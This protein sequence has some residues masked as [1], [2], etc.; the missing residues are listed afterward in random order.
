MRTGFAGQSHEYYVEYIETL[1][2]LDQPARA[3]EV[4]ERSRA[5][6]LLM[7]LAER[8]LVLDTDLSPEVV[9]ARKAL[10]EEYDQVQ[11]SLTELNPGQQA[12]EVDRLQTRLR[13]LRESRA[14]IVDKIRGESRRL[15][16]L[17]YPKP[18]T[19]AGMQQALDPGTALLSYHIGKE[20]SRLFVVEP[21]AAGQDGQA[22]LTVHAIPV[23]ETA[24]REQVAA[25][26]RQ[27]EHQAGSRDVASPWFLELSRRLFDV[28]IAPAESALAK[29]D[30]VLISPDGPL[31]SLPFAALVRSTGELPVS[32][33]R[34][35]E[36]LVEWKPLHTAVSATVYEE[37][38]KLRAVSTD[39]A[40]LVA[41]GD[42]QYPSSKTPADSQNTELRAMLLRGYTL[43]S[44]PATRT[45]VEALGRVFGDRATT[46]L[47]ASATEERAKSVGRTR[48]LHFATHGLLDARFPLNSALALSV[49]LQR[50][51]GQDNGLLQAWEIFEQVR[52]DADLVTLSACETALGAE[53]AGEGLISLTRAFHYA[54]ARSVLASLWSVADDST[55]D[56]MRAVYRHL[57]AGVPKDEALRRA[58]RDAITQRQTSL[59]FH[60]AAFTLS[61]D[62]R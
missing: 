42:P 9:E 43:D 2:A 8:D 7:V 55:A 26:R 14:R 17:Q 3:F 25:L 61:G 49:P 27:I 50:R 1:L 58:Q 37:L 56:L 21:A 23:G 13:D 46:Y 29:A 11:E 33:D 45:E 15:A 18:L 34:P 52:I 59:P 16:G 28:L 10:N 57:Q 22:R 51:E 5:R 54:G 35:W 44:L 39:P 38:K 60:W 12:A 31:H 40:T 53:L 36:Y 30:R 4:L 32:G 20:K 41:F 6:A 62:W 48:Y 24:L 19:L 47:G